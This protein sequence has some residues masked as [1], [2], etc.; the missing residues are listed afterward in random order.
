MVLENKNL[1]FRKYSGF[2]GKTELDFYQKA[3]FFSIL[4]TF[5]CFFLENL[6]ISILWITFFISSVKSFSQ[7]K[8]N[9]CALFI[10]E[11]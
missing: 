7:R 6:N 9:A 3:D 4:K 8:I 11:T 1:V 2:G 10:R 5:I